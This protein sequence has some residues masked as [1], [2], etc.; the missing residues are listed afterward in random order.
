MHLREQATLKTY[1]ET[2][3]NDLR[4]FLLKTQDNLDYRF[5]QEM[6]QHISTKEV[7]KLFHK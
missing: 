4:N 5:Y 1:V 7:F 3:I 6:L 2:N